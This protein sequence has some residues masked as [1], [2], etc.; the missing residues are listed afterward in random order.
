MARLT[1]HHAEIVAADPGS[2]LRLPA[3]AAKRLLVTE[4]TLAKWRS[5]G[6]GPGYVK[7]SGG[8]IAYE[9]GELDRYISS[10]RVRPAGAGAL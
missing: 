10:C 5:A 4:N 8:R 1:D 3:D 7:I 6:T 9:D 2:I